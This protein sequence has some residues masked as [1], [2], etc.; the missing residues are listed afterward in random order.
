MVSNFM[1]CSLYSYMLWFQSV[2]L[3]LFMHSHTFMY[4]EGF[5]S[6]F[7]IIFLFR[8]YK[9]GKLDKNILLSACCACESTLEHGCSFC[10]FI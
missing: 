1:K 3:L 5:G 8:K 10:E 6:S 4:W 9:S 2:M 7:Q